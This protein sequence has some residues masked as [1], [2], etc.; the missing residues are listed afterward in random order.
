[1]KI[2]N[3]ISGCLFVIFSLIFLSNMDKLPTGTMAEIGPGFFPKVIAGFL[4]L[5]GLIIMF[6]KTD[7]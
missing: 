1:M 3:V 4:L 5:I 7:D 2:K 6:R